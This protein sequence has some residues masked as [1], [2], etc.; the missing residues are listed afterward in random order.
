[1]PLVLSLVLHVRIYQMKLIQQIG[2]PDNQP[3]SFHR[4]VKSQHQE[5]S[6]VALL[7]CKA[8]S[9]QQAGQQGACP[10][11]ALALRGAERLGGCTEVAKLPATRGHT[12][13]FTANSSEILGL[14]RDEA[15][16]RFVHFQ[17]YLL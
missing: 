17:L 9:L 14:M 13:T 5:P 11:P 16:W 8:K 7:P 15:L 1:M 10:S 2:L 4:W 12:R 6:L 3:H